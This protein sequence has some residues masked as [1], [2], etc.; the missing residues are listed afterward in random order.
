MDDVY[1][2]DP[3]Q[4]SAQVIAQK[5]K[6]KKNSL[7]RRNFRQFLFD[8]IVKTLICSALIAIDFTLFAEAGSYNLFNINQMPTAEAQYIYAGIAAVSFA[9]MLLLSFSAFLQNIVISTAFAALVL[10][11]FNQFALFDQSSILYGIFGSYIDSSIS[12]IFI[13]Y[14][15]WLIAGLVAL[16]S[17]IL[18]SYTSRSNQIYLL[19]T[20]LLILGGIVSEAYFNPLSRNFDEK[21]SLLDVSKHEDGKNFIF[22]ALPDFASYSDIK[23]VESKNYTVNQIADNILGFY[24]VNNF[25]HYPNAYVGKFSNE[26]M[27]LVASLNPEENSADIENALLD[28]VMLNSYW[29]FKNLDTDKLYLKTNKMY[30]HLATKDYNIK[31]FQTRGI[32]LCTINNSLAVSKCIEKVNYPINLNQPGLS[33]LDKTILLTAQWLES[34]QII[35]NINLPLLAASYLMP[36]VAPLNF[37]GSELYTINSFKIFDMIADDIKTAKGNN[38]YFAVVDLPSS[39]YVYDDFCNLKKPFQ[40]FGATQQ[41]WVKN[42]NLNAKQQAYAEQTNCLIGH[43]ENFM[44]ELKKSGKLDNSTII[45]QGISPTGIF[46]NKTQNLQDFSRVGLAV[47]NPGQKQ[48]Q[49]A[50]DLCSVPSIISGK[51]NDKNTCEELGGQNTTDKRR[52]EILDEAHKNTITEQRVFNSVR[53][54]K[55]WYQAFAGHNRLD[56]IMLND[57]S[58]EEPAGDENKDEDSKEIKEVKVTSTVEELPEEDKVKSI[59]VAIQE[60]AEEDSKSEAQE[61]EGKTETAKVE[62]KPAKAEKAEET[63]VIPLDK[64]E[65]LKKEYKEKQAAAQKKSEE[66]NEAAQV[67]IQV[68]VIDNK[69]ETEVKTETEALD[70]VPPALLGDTRYKPAEAAE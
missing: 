62:K 22:L 40:W 52:K 67:N 53:R 41:P 61:P 43:L 19:G 5:Q 23:A 48:M 37:A 64:P 36:N 42:N 57:T 39:T 44:Q 21:K 7:K 47:Y 68:N 54:F 13:N 56:N 31:V 28:N 14:S 16:I 6:D 46:M 69:P 65:Q 15:H 30:N 3:R 25:T 10:S 63:T 55:E 11:I 70:V 24:A 26:F 51:I 60:T 59:S 45:I 58:T 4:A 33:D 17:L 1:I 20:L 27:N 12:G 34:T 50:Y 2:S 38:A 9:V 49:T 32:E 66:K 29:D 35:P 8:L 18:I